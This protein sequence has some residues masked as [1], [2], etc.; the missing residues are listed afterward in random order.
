MQLSHDT[1]SSPLNEQLGESCAPNRVLKIMK[2]KSGLSPL[3]FHF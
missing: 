2:N 1:G 3:I